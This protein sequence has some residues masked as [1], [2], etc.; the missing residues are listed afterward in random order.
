M[1]IIKNYRLVDQ[2]GFSFRKIIWNKLL[3]DLR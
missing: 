1:V 2:D 3:P